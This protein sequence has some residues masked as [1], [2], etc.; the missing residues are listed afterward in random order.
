MA[1]LPALQELFYPGDLSNYARKVLEIGFFRA[2]EEN[3]VLRLN[4][5]GKQQDVAIFLE[6]CSAVSNFIELGLLNSVESRE[7]LSSLITKSPIMNAL[8]SDQII[9]SKR[10]NGSSQ[11]EHVMS[12]VDHQDWEPDGNFDETELFI[13]A[14]MDLYHDVGKAMTVGMDKNV[15][16]ALMNDYDPALSVS[17]L[18]HEQVSAMIVLEMMEVV[19]EK[20]NGVPLLD[21]DT[22]TLLVELIRSHHMLSSLYRKRV[23][24]TEVVRL[25]HAA[26][27]NIGQALS[28]LNI[29]STFN[30]AD[31]T[32]GEINDQDLD[33]YQ[34]NLSRVYKKLKLLIQLSYESSYAR[35]VSIIVSYL[36]RTGSNRLDVS[37][38]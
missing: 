2:E 3:G 27:L 10:H 18:D 36:L 29:L 21:I 30:V 14:I 34:K 32:A 25:I 19:K 11:F 23:E 24:F 35:I 31:V 16:R 13:L 12:V 37:T 5:P 17:Y 38:K 33:E 6:V 20:Y 22:A 28:F 4:W 1:K 15:T 26:E 7:Y 8:K 9:G